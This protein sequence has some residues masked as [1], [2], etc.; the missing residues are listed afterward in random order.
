MS[1]S[2]PKGKVDCELAMEVQH[3]QVKT[4]LTVEDGWLAAHN[5][6]LKGKGGYDNLI[7]VVPTGGQAC[8]VRT[9]ASPSPAP[10]ASC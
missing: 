8:R 4:E 10:T 1:I 3:P 6:Y 9:V 5:T 7:R 2:G